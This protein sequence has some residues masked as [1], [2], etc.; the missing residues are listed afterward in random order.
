MRQLVAL[1]A[2][3]IVLPPT[4]APSWSKG[5]PMA[6]D[7]SVAN[8][9]RDVRAFLDREMTAHL[10]DIRSLNP[11]Q[12]RVLGALTTG[13]YTW[14]TFMRSLAAYAQLSGA[15]TLAGRDLARTIGEI[16]L[17]EV[18][19]GG[20]RFSQL[21]AALSLRHYGTDLSNNRLW[22][23][24][25]PDEQKQWATLLDATRF[26]DPV[27]REV[28]NLPENYLGVASRIA[29][30]SWEMKFLKDRALLDGLLD[31]AAVQFTSGA[32][33]ADDAL[34]TG[35]YDRYS[36]EYARYVWDAA[37]IAGRKDLLDALRPSLKEQMRL[38][39][40][41]AGPDGYG[42]P[43]GR[44]L[45]LVSYLDTLEIPGF[46]AL[47][48]EFRPA[49]LDQLAAQYYRAWQWL[50]R[51]FKNDRH[52]F[53]LFDFGRGNY[54]YI[55]LNREW[56]QTTGSF[57]KL[58]HAHMQLMEGLRA[59]HIAAIPD[60]PDYRR[61]NL[62]EF[63]NNDSVQ[64]QSGVW[65]IRDGSMR[66]ALP[67]TTGTK[68]GV[69][70]YLPA[71]HGLPGFAAPVEQVLPSLV[72][73]LEL[74]DGR[75]IVAAD[76]TDQISPSA[77]GKGIQATWRHWAVIG[78]KPGELIDPGIQS[79]V[80]WWLKENG[81]ER[82]ERLLASREVRIRRWRVVIPVTGSRWRTSTD[83]SGRADTFDGPDGRLAVALTH[84]DWPY[85]I[86]VRATGDAP[87][88]RGARGPVPLHLEFETRDLVLQP[89]VPRS[90]MLR[91]HSTEA[92]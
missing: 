49:P 21:Y 61:V 6:T 75:T 66:F 69:A 43:W 10:A 40:S 70:D 19:L 80:T 32:T 51:D 64:R 34:P 4:P 25:A 77:D 27:K 79:D 83:S 14:G 47:N 52:V 68:P 87:D 67:F 74:E 15:T 54:S 56:Q 36:N 91:L 55:N 13:E 8:L 48:P 1:L 31:R 72:P 12:E 17:V 81:L 5:E 20:T 71:P 86:S 16:G 39:W 35:R 62:I 89:D 33:F 88:G 37:Q 23:S 2:L 90:W 73:F 11:P 28:I 58:A 63:F 26:Y 84:A 41:L 59:E 57:G 53:S 7:M 78:G 44:S 42:Y 46:L 29:A 92:P 85:T 82:T 65:V 30:M 50:R 76:G 3:V 45:G 38:W 60:R 9:D 24:L 18:R 22:Q